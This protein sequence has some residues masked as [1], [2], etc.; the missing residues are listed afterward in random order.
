MKPEDVR[1]HHVRDYPWPSKLCLKCRRMVPTH[2][3]HYP[4]DV[5]DK[6]AMPEIADAPLPT[7]HAVADD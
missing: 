3:Y 5:S 6:V 1:Y 2:H 7:H 4:K